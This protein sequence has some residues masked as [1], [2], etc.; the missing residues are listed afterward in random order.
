MAVVEGVG[1]IC[2]QTWRITGRDITFK[3]QTQCLG[4]FVAFTQFLRISFKGPAV[5]C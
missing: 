3:A 5:R 4:F 1:A 2:D